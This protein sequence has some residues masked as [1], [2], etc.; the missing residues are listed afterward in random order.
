MVPMESLMY[1]SSWRDSDGLFLF[2]AV[3][4]SFQKYNVQ[5]YLIVQ[6]NGDSAYFLSAC[7]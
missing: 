3:L 7:D 1:F 5:N 6:N 4:L 2:M